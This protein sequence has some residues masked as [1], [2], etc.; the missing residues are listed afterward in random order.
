MMDFTNLKAYVDENKLPLIKKTVLGAKTL[1]YINVQADVK[2]AAAIN[3]VDADAVLQA[4]G[5]GF[6]AQGGARLSQR[7][8]NTKLL[9][10]N[11]SYCDKDFLNYYTSY[12]V[13]VGV[14][15]ETLPFEEYFTST[16][17]DKVKESVEKMIWTGTDTANEFKGL[18][19]ILA[20]EEDVIAVEPAEG[21][22]VYGAIKEVY[23]A[24]P[25]NILDKAVIFVGADTYRS[26][27]MEMVEKN[28]Y[29]YDGG[30]V[31]A[32]EFTLPATNTK[33]VAVNGL[34]GTKKI[35]AGDPA[36]FYYGCDMM[37]DMET[38]DLWYSQDNREFR[39]AIQFNGGT[40]VA[41]P[42]EVVLATLA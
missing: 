21:T 24:I 6:A 38:F 40:Q 25:E 34:N 16:I 39:L 15:K 37:N 1:G 13:K 33:V 32:K 31:E 26:F 35:V 41:F 3:I 28:F 17:V 8:I 23:G 2:G 19:P 18:L 14:G 20:G 4:G 12:A 42:S 7:Q 5:C 9:K 27:I 30:S 29:H 10:V 36:N 11:T 22:S